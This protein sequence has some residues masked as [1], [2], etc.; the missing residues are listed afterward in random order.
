MAPQN[1]DATVEPVFVELRGIGGNQPDGVSTRVP[2][3]FGA[4]WEQRIACQ[5]YRKYPG[6][7]WPVSE[8]AE[9]TV[10]LPHGEPV[11]MPLAERATRL[12]KYVSMREIRKLTG[13]GRQV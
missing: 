2:D 3:F 8:F 12:S 9:Q 11:R 10:E 7:D 6:E 4:M 1:A 5:T 13:T